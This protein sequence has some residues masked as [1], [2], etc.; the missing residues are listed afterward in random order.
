M[1]HLRILRLCNFCPSNRHSLSANSD[2]K[3]TFLGNHIIRAPFFGLATLEG[4]LEP[5]L[6][7]Q[8]FG[9]FLERLDADASAA[10]L[11]VSWPGINTTLTSCCRLELGFGGGG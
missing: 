8:A 10:G 5:N 1:L 3:K 11:T 4:N 6:G 2:P 9:Q 7:Y